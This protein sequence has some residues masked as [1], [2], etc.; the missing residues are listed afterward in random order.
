MDKGE[1]RVEKD[2]AVDTEQMMVMMQKAEVRKLGTTDSCITLRFPVCHRRF[3]SPKNFLE[4]M[5]LCGVS[6]IMEFTLS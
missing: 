2:I 3:F 5:L 4:S 6:V 1:K